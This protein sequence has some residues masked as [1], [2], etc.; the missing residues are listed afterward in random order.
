LLLIF[1]SATAIDLVFATGFGMPLIS[2]ACSPALRRD[3]IGRDPA[4]MLQWSCTI[5]AKWCPSAV[6]TL[7]SAPDR[8]M[9]LKAFTI[10]SMSPLGLGCAKTKSD[11]V[12]MPS[13]RRIFAFFALRTIVGLK[14]PGAVVP[15]SVFTQPGSFAT[16]RC[17]MKIG[18]CPQCPESDGWPSSV[19]C[20][21]GP[22]V[23]G[24]GLARVFFTRAAVV[25]AAMCSAC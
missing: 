4:A 13:G 20:R 15:R 2:I 22:C 5:T 6:L 3:A 18:R 11:L 8:R 23:D 16:D 9:I 24:S 10:G 7:H 17:A 1:N 14:I 25:G 21:N 19:V 12:V